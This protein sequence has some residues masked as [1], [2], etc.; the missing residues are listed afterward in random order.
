VLFFVFSFIAWIFRSWAKDILKWVPVLKKCTEDNSSVMCY[1]TLAVFR[2]SFALALFHFVLCLIMIGVTTQSDYRTKIQDGWW[3]VKL[4]L[5]IG[6]CVGAFFIP[7]VFFQYFGWFAFAASAIFIVIQVILLIDF[8]HSWAES[9]IGKFEESEEGDNKWWYILL[10]T[11]I[12]LFVASLGLTIVMGIFFCKDAVLCGRNIAF[13]TLNAVF[14]FLISAASIHPRVQDAN[15][16]SG[17]LQASVVTLYV[18][19]LVWSAM[20]SSTEGCNPFLKSTGANNVSL[21]LGAVFT[22]AAVCYTTFRAANQVGGVNVQESEPLVKSEN[23]ENGEN[24]EQPEEEVTN[25]DEPV[26]YNHFRFHLIFAMGALYLAMLMTD[27]H[28]IDKASTDTVAT[29]DTGLVAVW[30][31]AV[32]SWICIG[33]YGWSIAAPVLFPDRDWS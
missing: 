12:V 6:G 13:L 17:L 28:T 10:G 26:T 21:V 27:W 1:G 23:G 19:Y 8:A 9:W 4:I 16:K 25:P 3:G 5:L 7:N 29:V 20:M 15:A 18:T 30:V 33:L 32:T 31:K 22:I 2:I 14:C 24:S 11:T